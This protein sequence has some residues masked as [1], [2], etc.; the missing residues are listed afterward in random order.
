[1]NG[2][3]P[4]QWEEARLWLAKAAEDL[5]SARL[6]L[7]AFMLPAAA[8]HTQQATE[9]ALKTLLVAAAQDVR[10]VH[11]IVELAVLARP[12]WPD[13][14]PMPFPLAVVSHWY[15]TTR[16]PGV[17]QQLPGWAEIGEALAQIES[18]IRAITDHI[19]AMANKTDKG[20]CR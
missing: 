13:L 15:M 18:L 5:A 6:L 12:Y 2:N 7:S 1:M 4:A 20:S 16:Y 17:D 11:D 14:L 19:T 3:E 8:F 10:R 9:K